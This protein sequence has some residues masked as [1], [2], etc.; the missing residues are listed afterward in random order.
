MPEIITQ[1]FEYEEQE[2][3]KR[4]AIKNRLRLLF[5]ILG[6]AVMARLLVNDPTPYREPDHSKEPIRYLPGMLEAM[7]EVD[8]Q[9]LTAA[10]IAKLKEADQKYLLGKSEKEDAWVYGKYAPA[11]PP[12]EN[13]ADLEAFKEQVYAYALKKQRMDIVKEETVVDPTKKMLVQFQKGGYVKVEDA[14]RLN[15]HVSIH[16]NNSVRMEVP[17]YLVRQITDHAQDWLEPVPKGFVKLEPANG[18]TIIVANRTAQKIEMRKKKHY[19]L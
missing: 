16:L 19:E 4:D 15:G 1:S 8:R 9:K 5:F 12:P 10:Q 7:P 17:K 13:Q 2:Q 6:I 18:I 3:R 14:T 11:E